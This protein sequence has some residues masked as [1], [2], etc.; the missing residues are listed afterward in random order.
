MISMPRNC[1]KCGTLENVHEHHVIPLKGWEGTD[2]GRI[3]LCKKCHDIL[4][5]ML[6]AEVGIRLKPIDKCIWMMI[7]DGLVDF[8]D[9]W[10]KIGGEK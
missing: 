6:F 2:H 3:L 4:H 9:W 5:L 8:T 7:R 10:L 1:K